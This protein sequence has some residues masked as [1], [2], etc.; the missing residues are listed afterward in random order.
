VGEWSGS[1][2]KE[3]TMKKKKTIAISINNKTVHMDKD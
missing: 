2:V 1:F 3:N